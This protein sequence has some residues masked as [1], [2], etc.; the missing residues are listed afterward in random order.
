MNLSNYKIESSNECIYII[1]YNLKKLAELIE[2]FESSIKFEQQI[3]Q[4]ELLKGMKNTV[5]KLN[6]TFRVNS[7]SK[8]SKKNDVKDDKFLN[9]K[10]CNKK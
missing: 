10:K 4:T 3:N 5:E 6:E 1:E 7:P 9:K 8:I 2:S